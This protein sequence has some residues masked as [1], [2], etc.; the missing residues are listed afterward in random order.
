MTVLLMLLALIVLVLI[1][2]PIAVALGVVAV[3]AMVA[4]SGTDTLLSAAVTLYDGRQELPADR[5]PAV[6]PRG[7]DHEHLRHQSGG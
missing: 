1:N 6:H 7:R 5:D 3:V 4:A 2:V